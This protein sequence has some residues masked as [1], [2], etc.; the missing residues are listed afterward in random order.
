MISKRAFLGALCGLCLVLVGC[1]SDD[2]SGTRASASGASLGCTNGTLD[3]SVTHFE[4]EHDG[5]T[6]S[7]EI[8]VPPGYDGASPHPLVLSFHGFTSSGLAQEEST[9]M[10][11]VADREGFLVAYPNGLDQSWNAGLCCGLSATNGVDDVGFVRALIEDIGG[12][13]CVDEARVYATGMSNGGFLSHRLACEA[14]DVIAAVAPVAG[15][16]GIDEAA[17]TPARPIS[18]MHL[19]GTGDPLVPYDGGGLAD[20]A[21]VED[22]T[23]GWLERNGCTGEPA[24]TYQNGMATCETVD[25]CSGDASVTVCTI[26]GGGHCWPGQPCR[27]LGD[28]GESTT[29]I[30]ANEAMWGLFSTVKLP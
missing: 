1:G 12:R 16:L 21:S 23:A 10:N 9:K 24:V 8:H 4:L 7:Y 11:V 28:L 18:I 2:G 26:E 14:A 27:M 15:V 13:G 17:C 25:Q 5:A 22:S 30:D 29:D 20:S 3:S 19:H 6:R